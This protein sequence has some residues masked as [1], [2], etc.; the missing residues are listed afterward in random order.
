[1]PP[2]VRLICEC[3]G[4]VRRPIPPN[5]PHCGRIIRAVR[6]PMFDWLWPV[7]VVGAFFVV[8]LGGVWLLLR[9]FG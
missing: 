5:C 3:G 6:R 9:L 2:A 4:E 1:M 7:L 8:L